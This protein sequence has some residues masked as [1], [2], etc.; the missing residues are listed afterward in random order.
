M[1]ALP[2]VRRNAPE[3]YG[4][5]LFCIAFSA[6]GVPMFTVCFGVSFETAVFFSA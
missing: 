3:A 2:F 6:A 5:A 1:H 4:V